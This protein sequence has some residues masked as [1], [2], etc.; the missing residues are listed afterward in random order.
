[1]GTKTK[2]N[3]ENCKARTINGI[4]IPLGTQCTSV[5][6]SICAPVRDAFT[7][8]CHEM[9][10]KND[11]KM[12]HTFG[13][14]PFCHGE[15]VIKKPKWYDRIFLGPIDGP[16]IVC[17]KCGSVLVAINRVFTSESIVIHIPE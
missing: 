5:G 6:D 8:G 13:V 12:I 2:I 17:S 16:M 3:R 11:G 10:L 15:P 4:C 9:E 14:C 7:L 1:M